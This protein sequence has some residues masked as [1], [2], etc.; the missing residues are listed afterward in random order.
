MEK[1]FQLIKENEQQ[2]E[3][4]IVTVL[5]GRHIGEKAL[6]RNNQ[7]IWHNKKNGIISGEVIDLAKINASEAYDVN[8][9]RF[10][11]DKLGNEKKLVICGG[12]HV[13][14]ALIQM[15]K[16]AEWEVVV[17]EDRKYFAEKARE[18]G[19]DLVICD[20]FS[21]GLDQIKGNKDTFF[22]V[23]TRGHKYDKICLKQLCEK[24]HAYIGMIGSQGRTRMLREE[25]KEE[26][27]DAGVLDNVYTPIGLNIAAQTPAEIA[28]AILAEI[29]QLKNK[30]RRTNGFTR[31]LLK[32]LTNTDSNQKKVLTTIVTRKGSAPRQ[33][34]T[35]M[36]VLEDASTIGTIGGGLLES[37]MIQKAVEMMRCNETESCLMQVDLTASTAEEE[38]MVC[39]GIVEVFLERIR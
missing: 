2:K 27:V 34:G 39:G 14:L 4:L 12:G 24:E 13:S 30:D 33:V 22:A 36:L 1:L 37:R 38:G 31:E 29:I 7:C 32:E 8:G 23:L 28:V 25:L 9:T 18:S 11:V 16:L 20:S 19:A 35:K 26:G 3:D 10:F 15:A 17:L 6:F 5:A 21:D